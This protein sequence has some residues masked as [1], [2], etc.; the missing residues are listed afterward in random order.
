M[1]IRK[2]SNIW[3]STELNGLKGY[4]HLSVLLKALD[5][6][7]LGKEFDENRRIA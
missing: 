5:R 1:R 4:R 3:V 6:L 2:F 7:V